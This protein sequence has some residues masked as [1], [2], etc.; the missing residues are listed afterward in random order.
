[1]VAAKAK[2]GMVL[3]PACRK[4]KAKENTSHR[5]IGNSRKFTSLWVGKGGGSATAKTKCRMIETRAMKAPT[6]ARAVI[7]WMVYS[8]CL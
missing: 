2:A 5:T 4:M 3:K 8:R 7:V 6:P 1:M